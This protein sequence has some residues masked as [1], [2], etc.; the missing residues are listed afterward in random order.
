MQIGRIYV[1][2]FLL[3][4]LG[5]LYLGMRAVAREH[6]ERR[7]MPYL[8]RRGMRGVAMKGQSTARG[9]ASP[10]KLPR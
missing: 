5:A 3:L 2:A 10:L 7:R 9:M 4:V 8:V 1:I 6:E